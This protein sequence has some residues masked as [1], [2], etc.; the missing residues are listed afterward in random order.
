MY[1]LS[2]GMPRSH[3]DRF[4]HA[5]QELELCIIVRNTNPRSATWIERG[6]PPK[7]ISVKCHTSKKTGKVT[8]AT[9]EEIRQCRGLPFLVIDPDGV[10]RRGPNDALPTKFPFGTPEQNETGQVIHPIQRKA[11]VGDYDLMGVID[12]KAKGRNLTLIWS[13]GAK[14]YDCT[15]PDVERVRSFVNS[16]LDQPRIMHGAQDQFGDFPDDGAIAFL[17][18]GMTWELKNGQSI[19]GLYE[20]LGRETIQG[21][22]RNRMN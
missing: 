3:F 13:A 10:A 20:L 18:N 19:Q 9:A 1:S 21:S 8:A 12:P 4:Q 17:P 15:S 5:A 6:Y 14:V 22:Y 11:L 7:P 16:R 2:S